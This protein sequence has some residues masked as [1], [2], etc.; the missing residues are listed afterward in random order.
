MKLP[1]IIKQSAEKADPIST[2]IIIARLCFHTK[3]IS[4]MKSAETFNHVRFFLYSEIR[5]LQTT[6]GV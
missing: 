5:R 1:D 6:L 3:I 2:P 4:S